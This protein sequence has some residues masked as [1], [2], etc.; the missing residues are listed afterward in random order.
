MSLEQILFLHLSA[1]QLEEICAI[2]SDRTAPPVLPP[3]FMAQQQRVVVQAADPRTMSA[4]DRA[5]LDS[6]S[7]AND[8]RLEAAWAERAAKFAQTYLKL[9]MSIPDRRGLRLTPHDDEIYQ[10][11]RAIFPTMNVQALSDADMKSPA[12]KDQ[13][14]PFLLTWEHK[15]KDFNMGTLLRVDSR[16]GYSQTNTV[17]APRAQFYAVEVARL[18]EGHNEAIQ[19]DSDI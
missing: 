2:P 4:A 1:V 16:R 19:D 14:R 12:A 8:A 9:V 10:Q 5:R 13:W 11:F 18:R 17:I 3:F 15:V 6:A 7:V